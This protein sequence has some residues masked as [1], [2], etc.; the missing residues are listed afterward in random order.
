MRS[1]RQVPAR[2]AAARSISDPTGTL[3]A[4]RSTRYRCVVFSLAGELDSRTAPWLT[5][6][7]LHACAQPSGDALV[8]VLR[9]LTFFG[10]AGLRC[11]NEVA[12]SAGEH[13]VRVSL[14]DA[15]PFIR[16]VLLA[17]D[18]HASVMV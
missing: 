15:P 5:A 11:L 2:H 17:G 13:D 4:R 7:L 14:W 12:V 1:D 16:R 6:Q 18:L 9:H 10:A 8:V 3:R